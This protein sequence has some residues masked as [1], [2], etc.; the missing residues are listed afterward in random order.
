MKALFIYVINMLL[1][2]TMIYA[3]SGNVGIGTIYP[4]STLEVLGNSK[5]RI[6]LNSDNS[7]GISSLGFK[8][9]EGVDSYRGWLMESNLSDANASKYS[10]YDYSYLIGL[11]DNENKTEV[12]TVEG[13]QFTSNYNHKWKGTGKFDNKLSIYG[14]NNFS[15][16]IFI[17]ATVGVL[18][19]RIEIS[20]NYNT[21]ANYKTTMNLNFLDF[22][23]LNEIGIIESMYTATHFNGGAQEHKFY[24]DV[25]INS[26]NSPFSSLNL[27]VN[28]VN[29]S[30]FIYNTS[31][32]Y[33]GL[34]T[35]ETGETYIANN[36]GGAYTNPLYSA[37]SSPSLSPSGLGGS[38]W[39]FG[40]LQTNG[41]SIADVPFSTT[42]Y[43]E[44]SQISVMVG[45]S[46]IKKGIN[47][48]TNNNEI[49]SVNIENDNDSGTALHTKGSILVNTTYKPSQDYALVVRQDSLN[50]PYGVNLRNGS[51][52]AS[53]WEL[54]I[55]NAGDFQLYKD[56]SLK[57]AFD[58]VSGN[59][60]STSDRRLKTNITNMGSILPSILK[61][62]P[63]SYNYKTD[64][65]KLYHGFLAQ[66]L[67]LLFPELVKEIPSRD[68]EPS[69]MLVDYAQI[70]VLA[71][72]A[73]Q[74]QQELISL[75]NEKIAILESMI[76][77]IKLKLDE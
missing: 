64:K 27:E 73:I 28:S 74:E 17:P 63:K 52:V 10:M 47:V 76:Q 19:K 60:T 46:S 9:F 33:N 68:Q 4:N 22:D 65:T 21:T 69:T 51:Q 50:I 1:F 41:L 57:G 32:L 58:N 56:T 59:Y 14:D 43:D 25:V 37:T 3:Q 23:S 7:S 67:N 62:L 18:E 26:T 24:G 49:T 53:N 13:N 36:G 29:A 5:T 8:L 42:E 16:L 6:T 71:I 72:K 20:T 39:M 11:P 34:I 54:Y 15:S 45:T 55:T 48:Q 31:T 75:Q 44:N 38:H 61:L 30:H 40:H 66:E 77:E 12:Y 35:Y 2:T 70:S